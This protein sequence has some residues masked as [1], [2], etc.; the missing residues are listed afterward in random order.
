[1]NNKIT[2]KSSFNNIVFG[3]AKKVESQKK[4]KSLVP[5]SFVSKE[6]IKPPEIPNWRAFA[7]VFTDEQIAQINKSKKL[8][9]NLRFC[10]VNPLAARTS[11]GLVD[12]YYKICMYIPYVNEGTRDLPEGHIVIKE[13]IGG[14]RAV[15][16][17]KS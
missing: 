15:K 1:M 14:V 17:D 12:P 5:D 2:Y 3:E 8:P 13:F 16:I 9:E 4:V 6:E 11:G 10:W 7:G